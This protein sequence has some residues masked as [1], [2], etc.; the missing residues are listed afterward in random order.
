M[1]S[2][3]KPGC[4][5]FA[6]LIVAL[7]GVCVGEPM[8]QE[9]SNFAQPSQAQM[10]LYLEGKD[11][12]GEGDYKKA[13]DHFKASLM[14][15]NMNITHL[16]LGR[17]LY[18][19]G[20]CDEAIA[21]YDKVPGSPQI[22]DPSPVEVLARL[23]EYR[24]DLKKTCPGDLKVICKQA[25]MKIS[26]DGEPA[27]AC[28]GTLVKLDAGPHTL[29]GHVG[30]RTVQQEV[31]VVAFEV[32]EVTLELGK[33][34]EPVVED[35][36][37]DDKAEVGIKAPFEGPEPPE[38][39]QP[40]R[41]SSTY[42]TLGVVQL[43][44]SAVF[45]AGGVG[46]FFKTKDAFGEAERLAEEGLDEV[47]FEAAV[48]EADANKALS[49]LFYTLTAVSLI[50]GSIFLFVLDETS[51]TTVGQREGGV[52]LMLSPVSVSIGGDF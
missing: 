17:A 50:S 35:D 7:C 51:E 47:A 25:Q 12:F 27:R 1:G 46:F 3:D 18:K 41:G 43:G 38:G 5:A 9:G 42:Q 19:D 11:A 32:V 8:A 28:D 45:L 49:N 31:T 23:E 26:V 4:R 2:M 40:S 6:A 16:N 24:E 48:E 44:L 20:R 36:K 29:I 13:I 34:P 30:S 15:G 39:G 33:A 37:K 22:Q 52:R 10:E 14:V 21:A